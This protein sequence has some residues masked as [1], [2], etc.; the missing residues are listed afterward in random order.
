MFEHDGRDEIDINSEFM[1]R[2]VST[3]DEDHNVYLVAKYQFTDSGKWELIKQSHEYI[4]WK[5]HLRDLLMSDN[6]KEFRYEH[7]LFTDTENAY[8]NHFSQIV[9]LTVLY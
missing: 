2:P 5:P 7:Q 4:W 9:S 3:M 6:I 8:I 1:L